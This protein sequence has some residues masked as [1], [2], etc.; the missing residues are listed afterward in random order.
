MSVNATCSRGYWQMSR[1]LAILEAGTEGLSVEIDLVRA[2]SQ[3]LIFRNEFAAARE[4]YLLLDPRKGLHIVDINDAY[5][6]ATLTSADKI[7]GNPM[8]D[9]FPDNPADEM[10]NGVSNLF[11]SLRRASE[12]GIA[13][14]MPVQRYDVRDPNGVFVTKFWQP[15][16]RPIFNDDG[17][18]VYLLHHVED[19]TAQMSMAETKDRYPSAD[20]ADRG[21]SHL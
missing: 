12:R 14:K 5:G 13:D 16:N 4:P 18:L 1:E 19:V 15:I 3:R 17:K 10:A 11:A 9:I 21:Y 6:R 20:N 2:A 7:A 8:F